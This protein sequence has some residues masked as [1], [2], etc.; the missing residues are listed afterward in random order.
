M[1]VCIPEESNTPND[2]VFLYK[3]LVLDDS[4]IRLQ[5]G[6]SFSS[7][8]TNCAALSGIPREIIARAELYSQLQARGE[9]L[10]SMIRQESNEE[11]MRELKIAETIAKKFVAWN[12]DARERPLRIELSNVLR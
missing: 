9:D 8:G 3:S 5:P 2:V 10:V 1:E 6:L 12:I 7:Y 11:E 4:D